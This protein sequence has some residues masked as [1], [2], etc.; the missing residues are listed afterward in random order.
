MKILISSFKESLH[1]APFVFKALNRYFGF[2]FIGFGLAGLYAFS[3]YFPSDSSYSPPLFS[4]LSIAAMALD[5]LAM[6]FTA[7]IIPYYAYQHSQGAVPPFWSFIRDT[8]WPVV[9]NQIKA[10]LVVLLFFLLLFIPGLYKMIRYTFLV[11]SVFFDPLYKKGPLSALKAADKTTR[12]Y[13]WLV[14]LFLIFYVFFSFFV[15]AVIGL[16]AF[17]IPVFLSKA[18]IFIVDFYLSCFFLLLK[19]QLYFELKKQREESISC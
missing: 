8:V 7:F 5:L 19:A 1:S 2:Y 18:L 6:A 3:L 4:S 16:L 12:G 11:E 17:L 14:A 10:V 9:L 13:F 15:S